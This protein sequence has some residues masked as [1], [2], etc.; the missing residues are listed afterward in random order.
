MQSS[1]SDWPFKPDLI[2]AS[3]ITDANCPR[4]SDRSERRL[5]KPNVLGAI[6]AVDASVKAPVPQQQQGEFRKL[7]IVGASPTG[8][9]IY[10]DHDVTRSIT[11]REGV[12]AGANPV[13]HHNFD[14]PKVA[15]YRSNRVVAH[16]E[17]AADREFD[18]AG[19]IPACESPICSSTCPSSFSDGPLSLGYR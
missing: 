3:P 5:A 16:R 12:C 1:S 9:S 17:R 4:S 8:G 11:P 15:G 2:G 7:V 18:D 13:G 19:S 6:P 10:G 14:G